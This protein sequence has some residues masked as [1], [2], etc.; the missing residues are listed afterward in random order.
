MHWET[1]SFPHIQV[2]QAEL[3]D[4]VWACLSQRQN[5]EKHVLFVEG[6]YVD[7]LS[8]KIVP[9]SRHGCTLHRLQLGTQGQLTRRRQP[10]AL[11]SKEWKTFHTIKPCA[12]ARTQF[13]RSIHRYFSLS[14]G[15]S[16]LCQ[17]HFTSFHFD[18]ITSVRAVFVALCTLKATAHRQRPCTRWSFHLTV[19]IFAVLGKEWKSL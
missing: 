12:W 4:V 7:S 3:Q 1:C 8:I 15:C 9:F 17:C 13:Q 18:I 10:W 14:H 19:G 16:A 11:S 5:V 6:T 2:I